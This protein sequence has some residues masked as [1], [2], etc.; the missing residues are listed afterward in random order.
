LGNF[1]AVIASRVIVSLLYGVLRFDPIRYLFVIALLAGVSHR[2][3]GTGVACGPGRSI[4]HSE[5]G[6]D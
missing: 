4:D 6:I 1:G 2:M 5:S 3:L